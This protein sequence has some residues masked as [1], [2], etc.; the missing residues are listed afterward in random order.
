MV[1][2]VDDDNEADPKRRVEDGDRSEAHSGIDGDA[3]S[4]GKAPPRAV[5]DSDG[6][7]NLEGEVGKA[8][9]VC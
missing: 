5:S 6:E 9:R 2:G 4:D 1:I 3:A 7:S 8:T